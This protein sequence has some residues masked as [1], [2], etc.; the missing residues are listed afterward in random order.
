M[1]E[2]EYLDSLC[3]AHC[4]NKANGDRLIFNGDYSLAERMK[5]EEEY[6]DA[7]RAF[8]QQHSKEKE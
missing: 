8:I 6:A 1:N 7:V 2:K 4:E 3:R 5:I